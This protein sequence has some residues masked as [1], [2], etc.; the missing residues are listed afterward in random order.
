MTV[1]SPF[2]FITV[3]RFFLFAAHTHT[4][5]HTQ[6]DQLEQY[7]P[8]YL[9]YC[10]I[11]AFSGDGKMRSRYDLGDFVRGVT[12]IP[13]PSPSSPLLDYEVQWVVTVRTFLWGMC[14]VCVNIC[15]FIFIAVCLLYAYCVY[16]YTYIYI[17]ISIYIIES[18]DS[19]HVSRDERDF[20]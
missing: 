4:H 12:T 6:F 9:V 1:S 3:L 17:Y 19:I 20:H 18:V 7:V 14:T 11:W 10:I 2:C 5:T 16:K 13:L 15:L 8:R